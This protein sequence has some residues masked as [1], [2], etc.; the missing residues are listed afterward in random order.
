VGNATVDELVPT[1]YADV[2][3]ERFPVARKSLWAHLRKLGAE[4]AAHSEEPND[5][6]ARWTSVAARAG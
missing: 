3:E 5:V 1:V 6:E 2:D 4:G